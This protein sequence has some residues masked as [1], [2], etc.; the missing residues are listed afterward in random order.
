MNEPDEI[1][2]SFGVLFIYGEKNI[3][4]IKARDRLGPQVVQAQD[5]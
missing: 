4:L 2:A 5:E 1:E 3:G